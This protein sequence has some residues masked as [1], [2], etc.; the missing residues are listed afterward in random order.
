MPKRTPK[1]KEKSDEDLDV[2]QVGMT[3]N[4]EID[5]YEKFRTLTKPFGVFV[6][7]ER[8][9]GTRD[10]GL[11]FTR[12]IADQKRAVGYSQ[13]AW[14]Q[15]K[16]RMAATLPLKSFDERDDFSLQVPTTHLRLWVLS[17]QPTY[18]V[19]YIESADK[20]LIIDP[21]EY[22]RKNFSSPILKDCTGATTTLRIPKTHQLTPELLEKIRRSHENEAMAKHLSSL[23]QGTSGFKG[24]F[25]LIYKIGRRQ[26]AGRSVMC[27]LTDWQSKLRGELSFY[28]LSEDGTETPILTHWHI[29][30]LLS[31]QNFESSFPFLQFRHPED[32][33]REDLDDPLHVLTPSGRRYWAQDFGEY[34]LFD[35]ETKLNS[36]GRALFKEIVY[37]R[38]IGLLTVDVNKAELTNA[39]PWA[40]SDYEYLPF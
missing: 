25:N 33:D 8:D 27:S 12:D 16:G 26:K 20:F 19:L 7:Y 21:K 4:F 2:V 36:L 35:L 28:E 23:A 30:Y 5:Y 31:S 39:A 37:L 11:H 14:V 40:G 38:K 3:D 24:L 18:L 32:F 6:S 10:I 15:L 1:P 29:Q 9:L 34:W 17:P 22:A 13:I